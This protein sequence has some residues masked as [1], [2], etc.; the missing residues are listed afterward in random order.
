MLKLDIS[1]KFLKKT[2]NSPAISP[3]RKYHFFNEVNYGAII[4][5]TMVYWIIMYMIHC[6]HTMV[7]VRGLQKS[8]IFA[9]N[10][11]VVSGILVSFSS[12]SD[13]QIHPLPPPP[14]VQYKISN[15][16][17]AIQ[18]DAFNPHLMKWHQLLS[19]NLN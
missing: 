16:T 10:S 3:L 4:Q 7:F 12:T 15:G 11:V 19:P 1:V 6:I 13:I 5:Y 14:I 9:I 18:F 8:A 2:R 17:D